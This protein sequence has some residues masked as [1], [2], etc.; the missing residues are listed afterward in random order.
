MSPCHEIWKQ[1]GAPVSAVAIARTV[2]AE[3]NIGVDQLSL[4]S[5]K[6][7]PL[8]LASEEKRATNVEQQFGESL[9]DSGSTP[10][11]FCSAIF[12]CGL[13]L[14]RAIEVSLRLPLLSRPGQVAQITFHLNKA[15]DN[16]LTA[17]QGREVVTHLASYSG[18][19]NAFSAVP[20]VKD[21]IE[22]RMQ[23]MPAK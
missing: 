3:R 7:L 20:V 14:H 8:D 10:P 22:K 23:T 17:E 6:L 9:L 16:G 12:G 5:P 19:S 11:T 15:M 21:V 13:I 2:F 1:I 18:W 4:A